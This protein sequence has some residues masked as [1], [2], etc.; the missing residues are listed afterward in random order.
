M[1]VPA[2]ST[3]IQKLG[4]ALRRW[5]NWL[6]RC[7]WCIRWSPSWSTCQMCEC[8]LSC[9]KSWTILS[10]W[11]CFLGTQNIGELYR[12]LDL[13][14]TP[15]FSHS[16][17]VSSMNCVCASGKLNCFQKMGWS[18]LRWILWVKSFARPKSYLSMLMAAWC[19][20]RVSKYWLR[21][22]SGAPRWHLS[23][24]SFLVHVLFLTFGSRWWI[25]SQMVARLSLFNGIGV[26]V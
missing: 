23:S 17:R 6:C 21:Y 11:P 16:S 13:W 2:S 3:R 14:T 25:C 7:P 8:W 26:V 24:I 15:G 18:S 22:D 20:N 10:P 12:E 9:R 1:L 19:L 4:P 5:M